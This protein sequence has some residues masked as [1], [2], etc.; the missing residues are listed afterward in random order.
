MK[1]PVSLFAYR[2]ATGAFAPASGPLL[3]WR[4]TRGKEDGARIGERRGEP[5]LD[6]PAGVLVWLHGASVGEAVSL[7]PLIERLTQRGRQVLVTTGTVT[8]AAVLADRLP[9]GA[10]H[11][12][13]P[14]DAPQ[15]MRRFIEHWRPNVALIAESELWPNFIV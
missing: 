10:F 1:F 6:R 11:Q 5:G 7:L 2:L 12:F 13:V 4:L 15:F 14:L 9:A 8:S 3:S